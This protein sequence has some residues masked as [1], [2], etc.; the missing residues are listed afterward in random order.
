MGDRV[1]LGGRDDDEGEQGTMDLTGD[2]EPC[3]VELEAR[4]ERFF[5]L[6]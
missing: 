3:R 1:Q 5:L 6:F 2:F 4:R